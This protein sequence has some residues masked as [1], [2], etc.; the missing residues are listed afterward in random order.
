MPPRGGRKQGFTT[1]A[2]KDAVI[3]DLRK[4]YDAALQVCMSY[5]ANFITYHAAGEVRE[6]CKDLAALITHDEKV[7]NAPIH[8]NPSVSN[9]R[10][11][12]GN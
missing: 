5:K 6:D 11:R 2:E 8:S 7:F 3:A 10:R 1:Q 4:A 12:L 9:S